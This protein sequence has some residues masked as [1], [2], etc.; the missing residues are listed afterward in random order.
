ML[1]KAP[2]LFVSVRSTADSSQVSHAFKF[3]CLWEFSHLFNWTE[4]FSRCFSD[5]HSVSLSVLFLPRSSQQ[6]T[7]SPHNLWEMDTLAV[8][9]QRSQKWQQTLGFMA[10]IVDQLHSPKIRTTLSRSCLSVS[11][12]HEIKMISYHVC[13][14]SFTY[15]KLSKLPTEIGELTH[16][17]W[18]FRLPKQTTSMNFIVTKRLS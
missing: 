7:P 11:F 9:H 12:T 8:L 10:Q 6:S 17:R 13:N 5:F 18:L 14:I 16:V 2:D 15:T 4:T 3:N 1:W